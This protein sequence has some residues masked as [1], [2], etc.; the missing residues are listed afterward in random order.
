MLRAYA[1]VCL[2][3]GGCVAV[4]HSTSPQTIHDAAP[5]LLREG[6]A[7]V[8]VDEADDDS[9]STSKLEVVRLDEPVRVRLAAQAGAWSSPL[10]QPLS[11]E[12]TMTVAD[13]FVDCPPDLDNTEANRRA[14]PQCRLFRADAIR[15]DRG[16]RAD[17]G[18]IVLAGI[19]VAAAG[20]VACS[21]ACGPR[22]AEAA[23]GV[24]LA[25]ATVAGI[26]LFLHALL[27]DT[28]RKHGY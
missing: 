15:T 17:K 24:G 7:A 5:T 11:A 13:L 26:G 16:H 12:T 21:A 6:T 3:L 22:A 23:L 28:D 14:Y 25:S 19:L 2:A 18:K 8:V 20:D 27:K 1:I 9:R 4:S 10:S